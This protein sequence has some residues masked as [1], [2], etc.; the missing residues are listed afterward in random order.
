M[1][2]EYVKVL[3]IEALTMVDMAK[4][5][6]LPAV[7]LY[8]KRLAETCLMKEKLVSQ[9]QCYEKETLEKMTQLLNKAYQALTHLESILETSKT[10]NDFE[11]LA[12]FYRDN[13]ILAMND[14]REPCDEL[15]TMT[16][17]DIWPFPTYGKLLFGII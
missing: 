16:A 1:M 9:Q 11:Q 10:I 6:I 7:S 2:E 5:E 12:F 15:E 17:Q 3:N 14:L 4:K 8:S 13:L